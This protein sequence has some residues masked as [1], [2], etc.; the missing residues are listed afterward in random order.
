MR[1]T[2]RMTTPDWVAA[3]P[4]A[5]S[6]CHWLAYRQYRDTNAAK[7]AGICAALSWIR[8][9]RP[10]PMTDRDERPVTAALAQAERYA[11]MYTAEGDRSLPLRSACIKLDVAYWQPIE[12]ERGW[13]I[14]V[15]TTLGWLL[16]LSKPSI[17]LPTR[18][19]DG[20]VPTFRELYEQRCQPWLDPVARNTLRENIEREIERSHRLIALIEQTKA[21]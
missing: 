12:Y 15:E 17:E 14:G 4:V 20:T 6:D 21:A 7:P 16:K 2:V 3:P 11:A 1:Q 10:G 9:G 18:N 5:V 8:G 19:A 13:C